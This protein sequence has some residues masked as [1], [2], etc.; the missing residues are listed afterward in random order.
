MNLANLHLGHRSPNSQNIYL[1]PRVHSRTQTLLITENRRL[2]ETLKFQ[3]YLLAV[4][5]NKG[6][7]I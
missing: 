6:D 7:T 1:S 2:W 5:N 4:E 3:I